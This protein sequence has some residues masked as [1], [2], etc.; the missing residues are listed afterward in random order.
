A[1]FFEGRQLATAATVVH[2][3]PES[4]ARELGR[5]PGNGLRFSPPTRHADALFLRAVD[6]ILAVRARDGRPDRVILRGALTD[7]SLPAVLVMLEQ[8]RKSCRITLS[9]PYRAWIELANGAVVAAGAEGRF[10]DPRT[11]V[12]DL[13]DW[14]AGE[15]EV[16]ALTPSMPRAP[17]AQV[18]HLLLEH[19]QL[20]DELRAVR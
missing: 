13:L 1:M 18:T 17:V 7:I 2:A 6:R 20:T 3:L 9:G 12:F 11:T 16:A 10:A 8:E 19:A 4:T 15:V 5:R 14:T